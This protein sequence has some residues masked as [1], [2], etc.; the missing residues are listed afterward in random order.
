MTF[1]GAAVSFHIVIFAV[2]FL[3]GTIGDYEKVGLFITVIDMPSAPVLVDRRRSRENCVLAGNSSCRGKIVQC[4]ADVQNADPIRRI[5]C[6]C[7]SVSQYVD[8]DTVEALRHCILFNWVCSPLC[9]P[10][11]LLQ[12]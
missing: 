1:P 4:A 6:R 5:S 7:V 3:S 8:V 2:L 10:L 11:P 12:G 9:A